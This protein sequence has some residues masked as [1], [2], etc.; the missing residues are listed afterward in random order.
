[1]SDFNPDKNNSL[2]IGVGAAF[3]G[4]I[5]SH[6]PVVVD[7]TVVGEITCDDLIVGQHGLVEGNV[8]AITVILMER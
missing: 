3:E 6:G 1:M 2:Y 8:S 4:A 7:G 5:H